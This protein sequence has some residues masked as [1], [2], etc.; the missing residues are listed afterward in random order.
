MDSE[1]EAVAL[2]R[3][4]YMH[5]C[6][7]QLG[8]QPGP[9]LFSLGTQ[10]LLSP[11]LRYPSK[12][13]DFFFPLSHLLLSEKVPRRLSSPSFSPLPP[14]IPTPTFAFSSSLGEVQRPGRAFLLHETVT[15]SRCEIKTLRQAH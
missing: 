2:S 12:N 13:L 9:G 3:R 7:P 15:R 10:W 14:P 5:A 1:T 11:Q 6:K 4:R 8:L